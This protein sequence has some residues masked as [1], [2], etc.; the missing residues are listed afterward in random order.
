MIKLKVTTIGNSTGVVI[1]REALARLKV[2]K[3]DTLYM[4]ETA[5]GFEIT[6]FDPGFEEEMAAA[7]HISRKYRNALRKL[8]K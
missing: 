2:A 4:T 5:S 6:P 3:G 8:G 1:P 7:S